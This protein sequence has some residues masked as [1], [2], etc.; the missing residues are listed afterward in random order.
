VHAPNCFSTKEDEIEKRK[1]EIK[2]KKM[3][4]KK[5]RNEKEKREE[6]RKALT[7]FLCMHPIVLVLRRMKLRKEKMELKEKGKK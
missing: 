4:K 7:A 3:K 5:E 2:R 6:K 1:D